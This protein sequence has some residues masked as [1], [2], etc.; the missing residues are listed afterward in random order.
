MYTVVYALYRKE[1]MGREEFVDYWLNK[2]K[3]IALRMPR[4]R[5]YE[6]WP[7][8]ESDGVLDQEIDGFVLFRFDCKEDFELMHDSPEFADTAADA[9]NFAS[10]F[11]RYAVDP[12]VAL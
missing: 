11:T 5:S 3:A 8:T 9:A 1:G 10:H 4:M 6:I 7:V 2:H 12:H